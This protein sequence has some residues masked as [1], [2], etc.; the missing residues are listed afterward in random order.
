M[1]QPKSFSEKLKNLFR[2][3]GFMIGCYFAFFAIL[4]ILTSSFPNLDL[5]QYQQT[6][7]FKMLDE[8]PLRFAVMALIVAPV[9][10]EGIFRSLVKPSKNNILFFLTTTL[11]I[12]GTFLIPQEVHWLISFF[13]CSFAGVLIFLFLKAIIPQKP[14]HRLCK[15]LTSAYRH[16]WFL[17]SL[18]FGL[19]HIYNYVPAFEVNLPLFLLIFPRIIA[20]FF[21]GKIKIENNSLIWPIAMHTMNNSIILFLFIPKMF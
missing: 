9:L 15:M 7:L 14:L 3:Y 8:S 13:L 20:G 21:F 4:G 17:S 19:V 11:I 2:N 1:V 5:D 18:I 12:T 16:V 10:E 6:E